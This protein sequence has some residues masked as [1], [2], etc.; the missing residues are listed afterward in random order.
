M[1][2]DLTHSFLFEKLCP[3]PN[4]VAAPASFE[5]LGFE[6]VAAFSIEEK[7]GLE[8]SA[9]NCSEFFKSTV[10]RTL[11]VI[12]RPTGSTIGRYGSTWAV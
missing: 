4:R 9:A 10:P 3:I 12:L 6:A 7:C 5:A 11:L 1:R 8:A 2:T